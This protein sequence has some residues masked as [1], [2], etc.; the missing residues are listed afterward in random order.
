MAKINVDISGEAGLA[1]RFFGDVDQTVPSPNRQYVGAV[2]EM[3]GGYFNPFARTGFLCPDLSALTTCTYSGGSL[4]GIPVCYS[5][6]DVNDLVFYAERGNQMWRAD[7]IDDSSLTLLSAVTGSITITDTEIYQVNGHRKLFYTYQATGGGNIGIM[8][9]P[10][11]YTDTF[12]ADTSLDT[13]ALSSNN[14]FYDGMALTFTTTG[15]LP[16]P[17][18]INTTYYAV[19]SSN[20]GSYCQLSAT[21][22]GAVID[23][24]TNGGG[25]HTVYQGITLISSLPGG[26]NLQATSESFMRVADNGYMYIFDNNYV[27]KFDGT[28]ATGGITG[29]MTPQVLVFPSYFRVTDAL[30]DRGALY[31]IIHQTSFDIFT[32]S[33]DLKNTST[34]CGMYI[35][36]RQS[37][38]ISMS[39]YIPLKG[40]KV[41]KKIYKAPNGDIRILCIASDQTTKL[42]RFNGSNFE[43]LRV[44]G[45]GATP[46][47]HDSL[48]V[49][50]N[51]TYWLG[52]DG[53]IYAHGSTNPGQ[54]EVLAQIGRVQARSTATPQN[55]IYGGF[56]FYGGYNSSG[57]S[58]VTNYRQDRQTFTI[59]YNY[60]GNH[61][62]KWMPFDQSLSGSIN[63]YA[64]SG[65]VYTPV[66]FFPQLS[67]IN[68]IHCYHNRGTTTGSTIIGTLSV[69]LN[70]ST[71]ASAT[72][73]ITSDD[74]ARGWIYFPIGQASDKNAV[75]A[76]QFKVAWTTNIVVTDA[77]NWLPR[78]IEIDMDPIEK[79]K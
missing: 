14:W 32:E 29:V 6:D 27:H 69:Y 56:L 1:Q 21:P 70:Q 77:T 39:D 25:V 71:T 49:A 7:G 3:I 60:S 37:T 68:Y 31:M 11:T 55:T 73:N 76:I 5:Y 28:I 45:L 43:E 4:A 64:L 44:L 52:N 48:T 24:T 13:I 16:S 40:I 58:Q 10:G 33:G 38:A 61:I 47:V 51:I 19:N 9:L 18:A 36:D 66:I 2:G 54:K 22:G 20:P 30:D 65:D 75:F 8:E 63:S 34:L 50:S 79:K 42:M 59:G 53:T 26:T 46:L 23:I 78:N 57:A 67:K 72:I 35:W 17:L 74:V 62:V 41:V 15:T 12:T